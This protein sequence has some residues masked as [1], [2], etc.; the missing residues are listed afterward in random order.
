MN[1]LIALP[2]D[3]TLDY[4]QALFDATPF[5]INWNGLYVEI[6]SSEQ[7]LVSKNIDYRAIPGSMGIWY[8]PATARSQLIL[9]LFPSEEMVQ[10]HNEVGDAWSRP[11]FLPF[12]MLCEEPSH[13]RK[14]KGVLNSISTTLVDTSPILWFGSEMVIEDDAK[15]PAS[16]GFYDDYLSKGPLSNQIMLEDD[17][18]IE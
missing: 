13:R 1:H 12:I 3:S 7:A 18:G 9:P 14:S 4:F 10:R 17:E 6:G 11:V 16:M 8:D 15:Y 5:E 2:S